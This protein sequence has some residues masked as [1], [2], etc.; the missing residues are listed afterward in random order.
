MAMLLNATKKYKMLNLITDLGDSEVTE[1]YAEIK[2]S[3]ADSV[4]FDVAQAIQDIKVNPCTINIQLRSD[5][6]KV[7]YGGTKTE[8]LLLTG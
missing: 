2:E 1:S 8:D 4:I 6:F 7:V 3:V 5:D